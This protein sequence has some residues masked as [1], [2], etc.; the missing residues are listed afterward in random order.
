M[1]QWDSLLAGGE[2]GHELMEKRD[3][4]LPI[5]ILGKSL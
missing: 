5:V 2:E 4:R 3:E 1:M